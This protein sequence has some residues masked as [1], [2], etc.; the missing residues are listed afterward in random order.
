MVIKTMSKCFPSGDEDSRLMRRGDAPLGLQKVYIYFIAIA[1]LFFLK[2]RYTSGAM[3]GYPFRNFL[4][5]FRKF[6]FGAMQG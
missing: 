4:A 6:N 2:M 3:Q 1:R 5:I